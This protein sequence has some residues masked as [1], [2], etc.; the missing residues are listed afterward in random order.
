VNEVDVVH[1]L[2][3]RSG[4]DPVQVSA[5]V[6]V[7]RASGT[8]LVVTGYHLRDP[9]GGDPQ[10]YAAQLDALIPHADAVVTL[11]HAAATEMRH[12]WGLNAI[13]VPHPH[14]VDFV[15]MR[16]QRL[17]RRGPLRVGVHLATLQM[18]QDPVLLVEALTRAAAAVDDTRLVIHAHKTVLDV[19]SSS[20][21]PAAVRE[22]HRL[23]RS[24]GG[25]L[26][27]HRPLTSPQLWDHL[28]SVEISLLPSLHGSHSIWPEA[29]I[30]LG[31]QPLLPADTHAAAQQPCLT[32][33]PHTPVEALA[34]AFAKVLL[35]AHER[36]CV[37]PVDPQRRW[38]ERVRGAE[39]LRALYERVL[40]HARL[41]RR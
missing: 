3:L 14:V 37:V 27:L 11:T 4:Q 41:S 39:S 5:A 1:V 35:T 26:R 12:R 29:C 10:A 8:P 22:I 15:R 18:G 6:E 40:G 33:Y 9:N 31:T 36:Q 21:A 34:D 23:V 7:V 13:V 32:Y 17:P 20:Y 19:G 25:T 30:D 16:R 2:A 24:V 38:A 28:A